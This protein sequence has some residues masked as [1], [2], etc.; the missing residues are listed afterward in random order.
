MERWRKSGEMA[1][2]EEER[3]KE[4]EIIL[5]T[6]LYSQWRYANELVFPTQHFSSFGCKVLKQSQQIR[7]N[8]LLI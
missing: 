7:K 2:K 4:G 1:N 6:K 5:N 3:G 8:V